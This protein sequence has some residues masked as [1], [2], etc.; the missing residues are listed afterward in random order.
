M[1]CASYGSPCSEV[2][3]ACSVLFAV[4]EHTP[5]ANAFELL[6]RWLTMALID[7]ERACTATSDHGCWLIKELA[8]WNQ[9]LNPYSLNLTEEEP[10][11]LALSTFGYCH[12]TQYT[13]VTKQEHYTP[14]FFIAWLPRKHHCLRTMRLRSDIPRLLFPLF[15]GAAALIDSAGPSTN[16][17]RLEVEGGEYVGDACE[18]MRASAASL[19]DVSISNSR[20]SA[21]VAVAL[22]AFV[23]KG[24]QHIKKLS[25]RDSFQDDKGMLSALLNCTEL[26]DLTLLFPH[27]YRVPWTIYQLLKY[28]NKLEKLSLD[29]S[30]HLSIGRSDSLCKALAASTSLTHLHVVVHTGATCR[31]VCDA[32]GYSLSLRQLSLSHPYPTPVC[33]EEPVGSLLAENGG[34]KTL[35]LSNFS[36]C[37]DHSRIVA[38]GLAENSVLERLEITG[39][40][41]D[42]E[43]LCWLTGA[44]EKNTTLKTLKI[45][46]PLTE[47]QRDFLLHVLSAGGGRVD[48]TPWTEDAVTT[49]APT[50]T[51]QGAF[52]RH[53]NLDVS[54]RFSDEALR[55]LRSAFRETSSVR[56][57]TLHATESIGP[58]LGDAISYLL[59]DNNSITAVELKL[60]Y[61][62]LLSGPLSNKGRP[63]TIHFWPQWL[64]LVPAPDN[65]HS[66]TLG[67]TGSVAKNLIDEP[68]SR[69]EG[70][71]SVAL[72][73]RDS[74]TVTSFAVGNMCLDFPGFDVCRIITRNLSLL[75]DATRFVTGADVSKHCALAFETLATAPSLR[76]HLCKVTGESEQEC[77]FAVRTATG[78]LADNY[79][80]I[81]GVVERSLTCHPGQGL[82]LDALNAVGI[83]FVTRYLRVSD[84]EG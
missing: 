34:L 23:G 68:S 71:C 30:R 46:K 12:G 72:S 84:V 49:L 81:V 41:L 64:P 51:I 40:R 53:L 78:F 29:S 76:E 9:V 75:N 67:K 44:L 73:L 61:I 16:L 22:A 59:E 25:I 26:T 39:S 4:L 13:L 24:A 69:C 60:H 54:R 27:K 35:V 8:S 52:P 66:D 28:C 80:I 14:S 19:E 21:Q 37:R 48:I 20:D 43:T 42:V 18:A 10:G 1:L 77:E 50:L 47:L 79:F 70:V 38:D 32:V 83:R 6:T 55:C 58:T 31:A 74:L 56:T 3:I 7:F 63:G 11:E 45:E 17:R 2:N 33:A 15:D 5:P 36:L 62:S 65:W 82:Q 57:L